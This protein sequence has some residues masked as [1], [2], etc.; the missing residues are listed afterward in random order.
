MV[1]YVQGKLHVSNSTVR[2]YCKLSERL[3]REMMKNNE[4]LFS[5]NQAVAYLGISRVAMRSLIARK[6]IKPVII[7]HVKLFTRESLDALRG[8]LFADGLGHSDIGALY[9]KTRTTVFYQ[10]KK[11]GVIPKGRNNHRSGGAIYDLATVEDAAAMLGWERV[12]QNPSDESLDPSPA[13][14][15]V[16]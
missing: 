11:L 14:L 9:G 16:A 2:A 12:R 4:E 13:V 6:K 1:I 8:N 15:E 3:E 10:F 7:G 5:T